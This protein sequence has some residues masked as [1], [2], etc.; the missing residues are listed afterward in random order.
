M[1]LAAETLAKILEKHKSKL[2][3]EKSK[4]KKKKAKKDNKLDF[5]FVGIHSRLKYFC[6]H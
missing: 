5:T 6:C 1:S 4:K 2:A 3:A